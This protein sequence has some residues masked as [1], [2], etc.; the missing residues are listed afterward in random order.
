M[1]LTWL[2]AVGFTKPMRVVMG[3]KKTIVFKWYW[4]RT[5]WSP[6]GIHYFL[7]RPPQTG[8]VRYCGRI[9]ISTAHIWV[10]SPQLEKGITGPLPL[11]R[12]APKTHILGFSLFVPTL[13]IYL[14][15]VLGK[16]FFKWHLMLYHHA[17][18]G[19][20]RLLSIAKRWWM[21]HIVQR[22]QSSMHRHTYGEFL[23]SVQLS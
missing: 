18:P 4:G 15:A 7:T 20:L 13:S 1:H 6:S 16:H 9:P 10:F 23:S 22:C 19:N 12:N 21:K 8:E 14:Y 17:F 2:R 5:Q 11:S 3:G